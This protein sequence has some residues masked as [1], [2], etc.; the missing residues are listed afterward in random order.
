MTTENEN[1]IEDIDQAARRR[2]LKLAA[3][4]P[5]AILGVMIAGTK[6]AEGAPP[7]GGTKNCRSGQIVISAGGTACCPCVPGD[8]KYNP[9]K[10]AWKRC[11]YG[12]CSDCPP[13]PYFKRKDCQKVAA[14]C[15]CTCSR[16]RGGGKKGNKWIYNCN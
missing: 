12:S 11:Q 14:A 6:L 8:R 5:P 13:G 10:C 7:L 9:T 3:Y 2:L 15:G 16:T 1:Q 4:T